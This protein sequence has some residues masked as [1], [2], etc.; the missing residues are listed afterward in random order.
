[1]V[2]RPDYFGGNGNTESGNYCLVD[3]PFK[4]WQTNGQVCVS[5]S[6]DGGND[7]GISAFTSSEVISTI[8][9]TAT[10]FTDL[11][12]KVEPG[13]HGSVHNGIGGTMATMNSPNDPLFFL[14]H[15]YVDK[16]WDD[17]QK[18][19]DFREPQFPNSTEILLPFNIPVR[20]VLYSAS[21]C[22]Q[23][24]PPYHLK[25][26]DRRGFDVKPSTIAA[27]RSFF[28]LRDPYV[29]KLMPATTSLT[30]LLDTQPLLFFSNDSVSMMSCL[31]DK[32]RPD[33]FNTTTESTIQDFK[34]SLKVSITTSSSPL[35]KSRNQSAF[36]DQPSSQ[37]LS[38][39]I[40]PLPL[41][42]N[43]NSKWAR[44]P[45]PLPA[46][47]I[48]M[49]GLDKEAVQESQEYIRNLTV[50]LNFQA[51]ERGATPLNRPLKASGAAANAISRIGMSLLMI[52]SVYLLL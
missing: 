13:P 35:S 27:S 34:G 43:P 6:F 24:V 8:I 38:P 36:D 30:S 20:D 21:M 51:L 4:D 15:A 45:A 18:R 19:T 2:F 3:G 11:W 48:E 49:N 40:V 23:Y 31:G 9:N 47:W 25:P 50:L 39:I 28:F 5:R 37:S 26:Q 22:V 1:M 7:G 44:L 14:H 46:Y 41:S 42:F 32:S 10:S 12:R 16:I 52:I 17:Y 33:P 29:E